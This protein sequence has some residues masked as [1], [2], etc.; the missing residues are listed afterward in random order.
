MIGRFKRAP[1]MT[2]VRGVARTIIMGAS[3]EP[4][5]RNFVPPMELVFAGLAG[6]ELRL[7]ACRLNIR[8]P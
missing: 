8:P 4:L 6:H 1:A 2:V 5:Q 7:L 3:L